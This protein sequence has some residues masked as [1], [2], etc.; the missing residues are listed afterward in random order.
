MHPD[1]RLHSLRTHRA[2][3]Q[4]DRSIAEEVARAQKK[5][6]RL[7][8]DGDGIAGAW[9]R[10]VPER[11]RGRAAVVGCTGGVLTIRCRSASDRFGLDRWLR[12]GGEQ[13][14]REAARVTLKR[15]KLVLR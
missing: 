4:A 15:V 1:S 9:D 14:V 11:F 10:T 13:A 5:Y 6:Q 8:Q 2:R 7:A 3:P 12:G